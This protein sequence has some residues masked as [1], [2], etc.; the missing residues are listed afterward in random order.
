VG[1]AVRTPHDRA[2]VSKTLEQKTGHGAG[3]A[4]KPGDVHI[5][6]DV[7]L[8]N[9]LSE[10]EA[11]AIALWDNAAFQADLATLGFAR[12][13]LLEAGLLKNPVFSLLFPVGPKQLEF[14][15]TAPFEALWQRPRRVAAAKLNAEQ[16]AEQLVQHG[17]NLAAEVKVSYADLALAQDRAR[18]TRESAQVAQQ[19]AEI[20][21]SRLRAGDISELEARAARARAIAL[22][23]DAARQ[24]REA[25]L[26]DHRL[27]ALLGLGTSEISFQIVPRRPGEIAVSDVGVLLTAAFAARP[28]LRAA[29]LAMEAAGARAGWE[30]S[31]VFALSGMLDANSRGKEG[32]EAGPGVALNLPLFD[33]NQGGRARARAE[34]DVAA[35]RY[36]VVQQKIVLEVREA[37]TRLNQADESLR[38]WV[39]G[40]LPAL[41]DARKGA[42]N[43]L[44]AGE[45]SPLIV[46]EASR[47]L[48]DARRREAEL[49]AD[50]RRARA[51]LERAVGK[52]GP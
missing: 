34:M 36:V 9:G 16:M 24:L 41:E 6:P 35:R 49:I 25:E 17:L 52:K 12:A 33:V 51:Q 39:D 1:C 27:R 3:Q 43:S 21:E 20:A 2:R 23:E 18:W 22:Q 50:V 11:V 29:E 28:D 8:P 46:L 10:D 31:K 47:D 40:V 32:F 5:P 13:D 45:V 19:I 48:F 42:E 7:S 15:L 26:A 37:H 38:T 44:A 4:A 14:T 30:R